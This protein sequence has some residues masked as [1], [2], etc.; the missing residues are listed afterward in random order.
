[1]ASTIATP[2]AAEDLLVVG[3]SATGRSAETLAALERYAGTAP[4]VAVTND[5]DAPLATLADVT[6]PLEAGV[7]SG[8]VACRTFQHTGLILRQLEDHLLERPTDAP[9]LCRRVAAA[10]ADLLDRR[11]S[12]LADAADRLDGPHGL[13]VIAPAERSSS[14]AQAALMVREGPR[15]PATASETGDWG[16][17]D[18]Y[19]TKTLD[20]RALLFTGS[21]HDE[22][23]MQWCRSR[24]AKVVA[25]GRDLRD[26]VSVRYRDDDDAEVALYTEVIVAELIAAR[27]WILATHRP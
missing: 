19:L 17:V 3:I 1:V 16:H 25:V 11:E 27:W 6:V 18:V 4:T 14:A 12:W 5:P 26:A 8:G 10:T 15:R 20:Y 23:V 7:E 9:E 22:A 21:A 13:S 24:G 2:P